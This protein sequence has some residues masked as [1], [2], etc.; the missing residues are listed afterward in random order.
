ME[1][2]TIGGYEEVGKNMTA[3]KI[4][5]DVFIFDIGTHIP[6]LIEL[7]EQ[8]NQKTYSVKKL[9]SVGALPDDFIL[10]K[11]GWKNKVRAIMVSHAHLDHVGGIPYLAQRYPQ[12]EILATP[13]TIAVLE[14]IL[15]DEKIKLKNKRRT[16]PEDSIIKIKGKNE[17][18]K[19]EFISATHSTLQ[20][21]FL[22]LHTKEGIFFYALDFKLDNHPVIGKPTNY[23]RLRELGKKGVKALVVD[24]LYSG[25]ERRTPSERIARNLLED[26]FSNARGKKNA[27]FVSTFSSHIARLKSIVDFGI[28]T[29]RNI[30]FIGRSLNKYVNAAIKVNKCPFKNKIKLISYR[31]Q[32]NSILKEVEKDRGK[33][34]VVCTGHQAEPDS[35][36]DRIVQGDTPFKFRKGDNLIFSSKVI[37]T[38]IN[39]SARERMDKRLKKIGVRIQ[40]DV[41]VSGHGGRE[42][43]RDLLDILNPENIIPAHG[44]THQLIPIVELAREMGYSVGKACHVMQ[45]GQK[46]KL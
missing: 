44:S 35:M 19:L 39:I 26:A 33:Y 43:L 32:V 12:A 30:L 5:D 20:C 29:N 3:V 6:S 41:H 37:P 36:L 27:L 31:N 9:R 38:P 22:A 23:K 25:T 15:E 10:D 16:I 14:K 45:N 1:I 4:G 8:E 13:F 46:L 2:C 40:T 21:A 11:L 7:Q 28:R 34:L 18:Y 17:D 42:D 24:A